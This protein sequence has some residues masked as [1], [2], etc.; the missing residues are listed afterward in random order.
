MN[1][2]RRRGRAIA[3]VAS[4]SETPSTSGRE[5][6]GGRAL[7]EALRMSVS[8]G[9]AVCGNVYVRSVEERLPERARMGVRAT[10]L[11]VRKAADAVL[12]VTWASVVIAARAAGEGAGAAG[13]EGRR[14]LDAA[15]DAGGRFVA[16][17]ATKTKAFASETAVRTKTLSSEVAVRTTRA[18]PVATEGAKRFAEGGRAS[19]A[20]GIE[21]M[22]TFNASE[23]LEGVKDTTQ[24]ALEGVKDT[25]QR[26]LRG[27]DDARRASVASVQTLVVDLPRR[28]KDL[29]KKSDSKKVETD[30]KT[31]SGEA[32]APKATAPADHDNSEERSRVTAMTSP[33]AS[34]FSP[35]T[36]GET[37]RTLVPANTS[38]KIKESL[39]GLEETVDSWPLVQTV[40]PKVKE[41]VHL[42]AKRQRDVVSNLQISTEGGVETM[43]IA[44][45]NLVKQ[46]KEVKRNLEVAVGGASV[47]V[48]EGVAK[49]QKILVARRSK[50]E[51]KQAPSGLVPRRTI[52]G[53]AHAERN[54]ALRREIMEANRRFAREHDE[55]DELL[56]KPVRVVVQPRDNLFDIA[57]IAG[58][59]VMDLARYN[60]LKPDPHTK[61]LKLHL[62]QV[63]YVP[64]QSLLD[65]LPAIDTAREPQYELSILVTEAPK[66]LGVKKRVVHPS[67][68]SR[69]QSK[70]VDTA[71]K[72]NLMLT[73]AGSLTL[74]AA[75]VA[76]RGV[77]QAMEDDEE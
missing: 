73:L 26:A 16:D 72:S 66:K 18:L 3:E 5:P 13:R 42:A 32:S 34:T 29:T 61:M 31:H 46:T 24:K 49:V 2:T 65:R 23:A 15:R 4:G 35:K 17:A 52:S 44:R 62:G 10:R 9:L 60:N 8:A 38:K 48:T 51:P 39:K 68:H 67:R 21:G 7:A 1:P 77:R 6:T 27:A 70:D 54:L 56:T 41:F 63:L 20:A 75:A 11:E 57:S 53:D 58:I 40:K 69:H 45:A 59:S 37:F 12:A 55:Y 22:K 14:A 47:V 74:A 76:L 30:Q 19:V 50:Q 43:R 36:I 28:I 71:D 64:S 33:D 25:T